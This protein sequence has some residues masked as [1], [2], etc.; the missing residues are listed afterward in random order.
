MTNRT[1]SF[2]VAITCLNFRYL[3][4]A[5]VAAAAP[6]KYEA[7]RSAPRTNLFENNF[8]IAIY[9]SRKDKKYCYLI[10]LFNHSFTL[11]NQAH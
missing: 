3:D 1:S 11:S 2:D 7:A 8:V 6:G 10:L 4:L 9:L 5:V